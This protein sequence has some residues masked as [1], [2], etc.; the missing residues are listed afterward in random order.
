[1]YPF[2]LLHLY[3]DDLCSPLASMG[4]LLYGQSQISL[5]WTSSLT[6]TYVSM[7]SVQVP[8]D[9][10]PELLTPIIFTSIWLIYF[11][12]VHTCRNGTNICPV[13]HQ[14]IPYSYFVSSFISLYMLFIYF[15]FL[16]LHCGDHHT[17]QK[18]CKGRKIDLSSQSQKGSVHVVEEL[19][20]G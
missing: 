1:M 2:Y 4:D 9:T 7:P 14:K 6:L 8:M 10:L 12:S 17:C 13:N 5:S 16:F 3:T 18:E 19:S 15:Y 11:P 20:S